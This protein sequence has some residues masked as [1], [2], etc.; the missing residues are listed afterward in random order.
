MKLILADAFGDEIPCYKFFNG[1]FRKVLLYETDYGNEFD[2][3]AAIVIKDLPL[4]EKKRFGFSDLHEILRILR[5]ENGCPWDKAQTPESIRKNTLE[6]TYE[7]LDAI[8][9]KDDDAIIEELGDFFLQA[10]F[11]VCFGE[12]SH[13]FTLHDVMSGVCSKLI[14]RHTHIFGC[15]TAKNSSQALDVWEKNK[16]KEK[17]FS[18]GAEYLESVPK[19]FPAALRA[20]KVGSRSGKYNMDFSSVEQVADKVKEEFREVFAEVEKGSETGV[21]EECGD[22]LFAV[23]S[24]VRLL[25]VNSELALNSA[26]DKFLK[27]FRKTEELVLK[28]GKNM[29]ELSEKELDAYYNEAKKY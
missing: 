28:D 21:Y 10:F 15:D 17:G 6:E 19:S 11:Y 8:E 23:V 2:D 5:S 1:D 14:S 7:L 25:G 27:R 20:H 4:T 24:L 22:L 13:A 18:C 16:Q 29:K 3:T 12:E 9:K 26:T